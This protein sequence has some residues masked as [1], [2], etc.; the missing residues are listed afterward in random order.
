MSQSDLYMVSGVA[1]FVVCLY[2]LIV[3]AH[4]IRKV[5]ALNM[6]GTGVFLVLTGIARR[7][8]GVDPVPQALVL[9]GIVV[10]VAATAFA[11]ALTR[12]VYQESGEAYLTEDL[13]EEDAEHKSDGR[14]PG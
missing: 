10:T 12:R 9:T 7:G 1:I 2:A 4:L 8:P 13:R 14:G 3:H 5:L 11:L 6:M